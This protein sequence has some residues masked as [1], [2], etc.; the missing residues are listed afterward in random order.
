[1]IELAKLKYEYTQGLT[2]PT[3]IRVVFRTLE[4]LAAQGKIVPEGLV[5]VPVALL[6]KIKCLI[7]FHTDGGNCIEID[8]KIFSALDIYKELIAVLYSSKKPFESEE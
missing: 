4:H 5:A 2:D 7:K 3:Q 1:M 8:D 6:E